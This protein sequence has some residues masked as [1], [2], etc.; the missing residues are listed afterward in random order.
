MLS[1]SLLGISIFLHKN[2]SIKHNNRFI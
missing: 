2:T 1:F